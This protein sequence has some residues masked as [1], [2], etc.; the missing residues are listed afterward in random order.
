MA[1]ET[2]LY[3]EDCLIIIHIESQAQFQKEFNQRMFIY[4]SRLFEE[5]QKRILP[6]AIFSYDEQKDEPNAFE[7]S[8]PFFKI[9]QFNYLTIEL[10]KKNWR[11]FIRQDNPVA[12]ALLSKMGYNNE[13][14]VEVKKEFLRMM[15]RL[16]L[17]PA[18]TEMLTS[19]FET[20]LMLN[21]DEERQLQEEI[22]KLDPK[23]AR[24]MEY[25]SSYRRKGREEG[26]LEGKKDFLCTYLDSKFGSVSEPIQKKVQAINDLE[27]LD[28]VSKQIFTMQSFDAVQDILA[29]F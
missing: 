22:E 27:L 3:D 18:R 12:G 21:D 10:N 11:E 14:K 4:F 2:K 28:R 23:E 29:D 7:M 16:K 19:F 17:D 20:Y 24:G 9:L 8:L 15:I 1:A 25:I 6:I 13:E 5:H 26:K